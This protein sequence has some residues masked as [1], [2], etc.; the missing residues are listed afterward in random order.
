M[1]KARYPASVILAAFAAT[2][3]Q[4][5]TAQERSA[6]S[7]LSGQ[8]SMTRQ[9]SLAICV[10]PK[11]GDQE[12]CSTSGAVVVP[13]SNIA[14]GSVTYASGIGCQ[15]VTEVINTL[16]PSDSPPKLNPVTV[17]V[18]QLTYDSSTG[19]GTASY[20]AYSG[21][22]CKGASFISKGAKEE[23]AGT[24]QFV[25]TDGGNRVVIV[26]TALQSPIKSLGSVSLGDTDL[27]L[28]GTSP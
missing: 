1:K 21:G 24:E 17:V 7:P 9:G 15:T 13:L 5:A 19:I 28:K 6:T 14:N 20:T 8:Y 22:S 25:V 27:L 12:A 2:L 16:P 26:I 18:K 23:V 11:T 4:S 10:N 3:S